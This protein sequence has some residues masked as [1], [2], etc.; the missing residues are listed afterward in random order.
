MLYRLTMH[1]Q[2]RVLIVRGRR[3]GRRGRVGGAGVGGE[4]QPIGTAPTITT[5]AFA[6]VRSNDAGNT[7]SATGLGQ[8]SGLLPASHLTLESAIQVNLSNETVRLPIY[9]GTA[10]VPGNH[11][12]Q[13][14][15]RLVHPGGRLG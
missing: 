11:P 7:G 6:T 8:L 2:R 13:T 5:A 1:L 10:P 12:S 4:S 15:Q 14:E 3:R 9:P